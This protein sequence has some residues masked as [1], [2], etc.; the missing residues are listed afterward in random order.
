MPRW[1]TM[2]EPAETSWP[3]P[4]FTP[5]RW[6][7]LSR[8]FFELEPAFLCAI[9]DYSSFFVAGLR[10]VV[11]FLAAVVLGAALAAVFGSAFALAAVDLVA[12]AVFFSAG[13]AAVLVVSALVVSA[14]VAGLAASTRSS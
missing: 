9:S 7:T 3:S 12:A 13:F 1:R 5:R 4:A 14:L 6:P 2:I 11:V 10:G 8:P